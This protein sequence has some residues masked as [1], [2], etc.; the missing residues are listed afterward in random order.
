MSHIQTQNL[1]KIYG[2][3]ATAVTALDHVNLTVEPGE[4]VAVMGPS[5]CGKSTLLHLA[6]GLDRPSEGEVFIDGQ[7]LAG[8]PDDALTELRRRRIGFIFQ[9]FNLIPVL[10]ALE[11]TA[12][13]LV[14]DNAKPAEARERA[15]QWLERFDLS[16]RLHQ[17]QAGVWDKP[18]QSNV[19]EFSA[20]DRVPPVF[21]RLR[22]AAGQ[23]KVNGGI[24]AR[25]VEDQ[26]HPSSWV[27]VAGVD[28]G[29]AL[30]D[31]QTSARFACFRQVVVSLQIDPVWRDNG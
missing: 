23:Y 18:E 22:L 31:P 11:N 7:S 1:T 14:L 2:T 30:R 28:G 6:G 8:L 25:Q 15:A 17:R 5:G 16:G 4:F 27:K 26:L 20:H 24:P 12:L 13:P 21:D 3:G 19:L 29:K 10:D 9:F